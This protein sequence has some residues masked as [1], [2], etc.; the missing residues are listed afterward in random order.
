MALR[1][2]AKR[3]VPQLSHCPGIE[4]FCRQFD[5]F[6]Q[7]YLW[8]KAQLSPCFLH[9]MLVVGAEHHCT[10]PGHKRPG[11]SD[12]SDTPLSNDCPVV[13][14]QIGQVTLWTNASNGI[15]NSFKYLLLRQGTIISDVVDITGSLL[16]ISRQQK[17]L[18]DVGHIAERQCVVPPSDN[19]TL[20]VLHFLGHTPK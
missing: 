2:Q 19:H 17:T 13:N 9:T 7:V 14:R 20:A 6:A 3:S 18:D 8:L 11:T 5:A 10:K 4:P 1:A 12:A 16:V 15:C